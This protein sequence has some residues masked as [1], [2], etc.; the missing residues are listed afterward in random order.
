[1]QRSLES[2][3][4]GQSLA[5]TFQI[6]YSVSSMAAPLFRRHMGNVRKLFHLGRLVCSCE[7]ISNLTKQPACSLCPF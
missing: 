7:Y 3:A 2:I 6:V 5:E 1:M 4:V